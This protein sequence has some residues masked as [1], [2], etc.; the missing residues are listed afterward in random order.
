LV[1]YRLGGRYGA[2]IRISAV[3]LAYKRGF[4]V[5]DTAFGLITLSILDRRMGRDK[6]ALGHS[7]VKMDVAETV[8]CESENV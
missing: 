6:V 4:V 3:G 8:R 2:L 5:R 1:V 7:V